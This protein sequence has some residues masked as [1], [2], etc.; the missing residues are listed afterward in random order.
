MAGAKDPDFWSVRINLDLRIILH[1]PGGSAYGPCRTWVRIVDTFAGGHTV[2]DHGED[3]SDILI[4]AKYLRGAT[5]PTKVSDAMAADLT[6]YP[7]GR[8]ILFVVYD[9]Q[10]MIR[11]DQVFKRDFETL[12]RCTVLVV[13]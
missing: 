6:K 9:P 8:H 1:L 11:D 5:S 7:Q 2:P 3:D 12:G 4:E 13:R 10:R